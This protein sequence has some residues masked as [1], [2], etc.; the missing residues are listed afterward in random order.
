MSRKILYIS[1]SRADY[2]LMRSVLSAI[3]LDPSMDLHV[4]VTGMHLMPEFGSTLEEIKQDGY[5]CHVIN[6]RHEGDS[7]DSMALFLGI[8]IQEFV[9][10]VKTLRPD[11]ILILGD[12]G[13][14]L[15][16]AIVGA[17]MGI[18]VVHIHGG[19]VTS[20]V[21]E[22]A[23]HAITKLS[24]IHLPATEESA[25]RI[26]KMGEDPDHVFV[27]GAPGLDQ[28]RLIRSSPPG[29]IMGGYHLDPDI[30]VII[31]LQHPVPLETGDPAIQM[32]QTL[33]AVCRTDC[34]I[35]VIYPNADA[36]GRA[37]IE[38][39][40]KYASRSN[41]RTFP[42]LDHLDF[43][44]LL[45]ISSVLVGNSSSGI[46]EAPSFGVPVVNI[47]SR[48]RGRQKGENV[49]DTGHNPDEIELA[50]DRALHDN[51]FKTKVKTADNPY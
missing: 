24:H 14:M 42:S 33:K 41:I 6:A 7:R 39:I 12:R 17:Y 25:R 36:G 37:M 22:F 32:D 23:R 46:I 18:P 4:A 31:V 34:Q 44:N 38:V 5:S 30:P 2:G 47:G 48:Q 35:L 26:T 15:G 45:K 19:E 13:E 43:L 1:G 10:L 49:I 20:T 29:E 16:G 9:P 8:F 11:I 27:V 50:V 3:H 40:K 51:D 28:I 21:D